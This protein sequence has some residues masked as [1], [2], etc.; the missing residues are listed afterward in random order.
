M[1]PAELIDP[2]FTA[3]VTDPAGLLTTLFLTGAYPIWPWLTYLC[4][5][6][7]VGAARSP[8]TRTAAVLAAYRCRCSSWRPRPC[9]TWRW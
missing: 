8:R 7:A 9:P 5:G 2:S 4:V 3:L 1:P 6:M